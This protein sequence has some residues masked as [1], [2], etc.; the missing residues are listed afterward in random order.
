[1]IFHRNF[2]FFLFFILFSCVS[3]VKNGVT[4]E[5]K[6]RNFAIAIHGGAGTI[7]KEKMSD[8]LE[9]AYV[10]VLSNSIRAGHQI[11]KN[12]GSSLDAVQ[13][14]IK[15]MEDSPLFNAGKGA[16]FTNAK[17]NELDACIMDGGT[18][19]AG[20]I[21][22]VKHIK[23]PINLARLVMDK[24]EHVFMYGDGAEAFA[25]EQGMA[26]VDQSYFYTQHRYDHLIRVQKAQNQSATNYRN[27]KG[28][29]DR[30]EN[31]FYGPGL[32]SSKFG[33][34]G[35][36]ALDQFGNLAAGTSTGG[37]T[38]KRFG[39]IGDTPVV[40]AGT[41]AN[42]KSCAV[43]ATGWGEFFIRGVAAYDI[44]AMMKYGGYSLDEATSQVIEK[45]I[46]NMGGAG[47]VI[48]MDQSGS[49]SVKFNTPGMYRAQIDV[50]G[51]LKVG[52]YKSNQLLTK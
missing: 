38:N 45:K 7:L 37:M 28:R 31:Q 46:P 8:S 32:R 50:H 3:S 30:R 26:M 48:A 2:S 5:G 4:T 40:G 20:A 16:V 10:S 6:S 42:N 43:S 25:S 9:A 36:I 49:I 35:C 47:G 1:M 22:G 13:A 52:I 11:L 44:A 27:K 23:N 33:T 18:L 19:K 15:I 29:S 12:G 14:S 51:Q 39:R 41:Y 21:S 17:N 34:V 24:S